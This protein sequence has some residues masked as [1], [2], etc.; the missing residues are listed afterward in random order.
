MMQLRVITIAG[1]L[2]LVKMGI[3]KAS[4]ESLSIKL[5]LNIKYDSKN[6]SASFN[7]SLNEENNET[8]NISHSGRALTTNAEPGNVS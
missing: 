8:K 1:V 2:I 6:S 4:L 5:N 3:N 7:N